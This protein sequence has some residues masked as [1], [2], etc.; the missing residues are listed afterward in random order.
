MDTSNPTFRCLRRWN[1]FWLGVV[2]AAGLVLGAVL[3][4]KT[5]SDRVTRLEISWRG[6]SLQIYSAKDGPFVVTHLFRQWSNDHESCVAQLPQPI[7]IIDSKGYYISAQE[8]SAL[9]WIG[10]SGKTNAPPP[11]G[12][13]LRAFYLVPRQTD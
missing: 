4:L 6:D 12:T 8:I 1:L 9:T 2:T 5:I 11:A 3:T 10:A 13:P 7:T